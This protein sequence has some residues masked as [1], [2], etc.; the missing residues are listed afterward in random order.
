MYVCIDVKYHHLICGVNLDPDR[1]LIIN[2]NYSYPIIVIELPIV[3]AHTL[4]V[5]F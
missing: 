2:W 4:D 5:Y 1:Y 3:Y